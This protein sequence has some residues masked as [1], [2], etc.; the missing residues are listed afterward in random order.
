MENRE[1]VL[2]EETQS[3]KSSWIWQLVLVM[4]VSGT[5]LASAAMF[6][7]EKDVS[8]ALIV[9]PV[10]IL[11][12][13]LV[14]YLIYNMRLQIIITRKG[15]SYK[16]S[17]NER[18]FKHIDWSEIGTIAIRKSPALSYGKKRKIRYGIVY[19]MSPK[20]SKGPELRLKDGKI[21]FLSCTETETVKLILSK[22]EIQVPVIMA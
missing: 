11:S 16:F 9:I 22:Q 21:I 20:T 6:F 18:T 2:W 10:V 13:L 17:P 1:R 3:L 7:S 4:S 15:I 14:L 12:N 5:L 8:A 19:N